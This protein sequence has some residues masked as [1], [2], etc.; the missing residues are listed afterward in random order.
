MRC[1]R[2]VLTQRLEIRCLVPLGWEHRRWEVLAVHHP[3]R[4]EWRSMDACCNP[5]F[6]EIRWFI[7]RANPLS[8]LE[9]DLQ[10]KEEAS[11]V[12]SR[13][14]VLRCQSR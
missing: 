6:Q 11:K 2:V 13:P 9:S 7:Q 5:M 4:R 3:Q 8:S 12:F 14:P 10:H 1:E